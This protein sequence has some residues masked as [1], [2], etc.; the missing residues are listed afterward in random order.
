MLLQP[1]W[2]SARYKGRVFV[3]HGSGQ[4]LSLNQLISLLEHQ[5]HRSL[6]VQYLPSRGC[7]VPANVL[8]I[9]RAK[10]ALNWTP[11][12]SVADGIA[13]ALRKP[14]RLNPGTWV[15]A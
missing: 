5:L 11:K 2:L 10:E 3:Q 14:Q 13:S 12:I 1:Y 9:E 6:N 4:G 8:C 15:T 7:D